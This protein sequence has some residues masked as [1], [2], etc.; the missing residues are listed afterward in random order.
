MATE[1]RP[2]VGG[3]FLVTPV[4]ETQFFTVDQFDAEQREVRRTARQF[5][6]TEVLPKADAIDH[7]EPG[8]LRTL[9]RRAGELGLL[10]VDVP[11]AHGGLDL[12]LVYSGIVGSELAAEGSFAVCFGTQTSIGL[13]PIVYYGNAD[14]QA[15]FLPKMVTGEMVSCYMLT[16]PGVGSDAMGIKTRAELAPDGTHYILNG[17]KQWISNG[18]IADIGIAFAKIDDV[19]FTAFIVD[20]HAPGVRLS[21]E[22]KKMGIKGSSTRAVFFENVQVPVENVLGEIGKGHKIAFN[23]LN[24][25]RL[26]LSMGVSGPRAALK[27]ATEFAKTRKAFGKSIGQFGMIQMKLAGMAAETYAVE[28]M[29]FRIAGYIEDAR[30]AAGSDHQAQ[31]AAI[32]EFAIEASLGKVFGTEATG[33]VVDDGVQIFGGNGFMQ[34]YPIEKAYRDA[35]ITRIFE[36]TNEINRMLAAGKLFERVMANKIDLFGAFNAADPE[37]QQGAAPDFTVGSSVPSA[38]RSAVNVVE[39]LK[40]AAIYTAMKASM[41]YVANIRDEQEYL[42]NTADMMLGIFAM[43][44]AVGRA[45]MAARA[46]NPQAGTQALLANEVVYRQLPGVRAAMEH[47]VEAAFTGAD[48]ANELKVLRAYVADL[49]VSGTE[50]S[51]ALAALVLEQGGY[52]LD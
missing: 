9:L 23:I 48:R 26:K 33:R 11:D 31:M 32:E 10:G 17:A 37:I 27:G 15:R 47:I 38:L 18:G 30:A 3:G 6:E 7:Q 28:S 8:L 1:V 25:G 43:D 40:R 24:I 21:P 29:G 35:R 34:E 36:G 39:S 4:T 42:S 16:E 46:N 52:P 12:G 2:I 19:K 14:Q 20:M 49:D 50:L 22:E 13:L 41:K 51:R 5:V 45:L 44:S